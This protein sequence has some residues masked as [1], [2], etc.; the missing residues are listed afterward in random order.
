MCHII[1]NKKICF[2]SH[3]S[4]FLIFK[5]KYLKGQPLKLMMNSLLDLN[6][7]LFLSFKVNQ[8]KKNEVVF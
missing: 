7:S 4:L 3:I 2:N 5:L 6:K 8:S 1:K